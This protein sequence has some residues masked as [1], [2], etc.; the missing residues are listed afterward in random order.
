MAL[1]VGSASDLML[2]S[3][4]V[5]DFYS[6]KWDRPIALVEE[7]FYN[8]QFKSLP[9]STGVDNCVVAYDSE[10]DAIAGVM[11]VNAR[12]FLLAGRELRG[13]EATSWIISEEYRG[14]GVGR[15]MMAHV[16]SAFQAFIG[17]GTSALA[18]PMRLR[19]GFRY[20]A[21]IPRF[22]RV[23][24]FDAIAS[25]AV[26]E[27][28]AERLWR[29]WLGAGKP[30]G[31]SV[32]E[33]IDSEADALF[34]RL[35][36]S[37]NLFARDAR[38]LTWR[39][40]DH[41]MFKYRLFA[42]RPVGAEGLAFVALREETAVPG[43]I[44]YHVTDCIGDETA[45]EAAFTFID[46]FCREN[47]AHLADFYCTSSRINRYPL[48]RGWFS[49]LDDHFFKFPHLFHPVE[50]RV[51]ATTSMTYW[52]RDSLVEMCDLSRLYITKEDADFDRPVLKSK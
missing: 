33:G 48:S 1:L 47:G 27:P 24:D 20:L 46:D 6:A 23:Y 21:A 10:K 37:Y 13:G 30:A 8:W 2:D 52:A 31:Y 35:K 22:V 49:T 25:L 7:R 19:S 43:V 3:S 44:I 12:P 16:M 5:R 32:T 18:L 34:E 14:T 51:P 42:V 40:V 11:G 28:L 45:M 15:Q 9:L 29:Q 26:Y 4:R 50:F 39:Y 36:A 17:M 38:H 41:P